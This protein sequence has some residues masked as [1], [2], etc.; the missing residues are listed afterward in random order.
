MHPRSAASRLRIVVMG[1]LIRGPIGGLAWHYLQYVMGLAALGH[2][3]LY[4]EDSDDYDSCYDPALNERTTNPTYGLAFADD[5][6]RGVGLGGCWA[7]HDSHTMRWFGPR[8]DR[9]PEF[10]RTADVCLNISG[11]NPIRPWV[12]SIPVRVLIDTDPAFTQIK[13]LTDD[14]ASQLAH[15][16]N[17]FFTFAENLPAGRSEVPDD[18]LPWQATRQ[19]VVLDA[20]PV[21]PAPKDGKYTSVLLWESYDARQYGGREYGLKAQSFGPYVM[22]PKRTGPIFELAM[23][24]PTS[25][26][27]YFQE[28]GWGVI[29]PL[30]PTRDPWSYQRYIQGSRAEF[31]VAKHAYV[32]SRSGWFSERSA[33]YLASGRPVIVQDTGFSDWLPTGHG[34][35]PFSNP[36]EVIAAI[37][38][39]EADYERHCR[40]A[41]EVA[42]SHFEAGGV[43]TKLL[44]AAWPASHRASASHRGV[45]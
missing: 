11:M 44:E 2:E 10:C 22:L 39:V 23:G 8:A 24:S 40:A 1:Y 20:W 18:G 41:R 31:G 42:Q 16:H 17:V 27:E 5:A 45:L 25:P 19:P 15:R 21:V 35:L 14:D 9:V 43:L 13:H 29:D 30:E 28:V 4:L 32:V 6:F 36:D 26:G 38:S 7:F 3:V 37:A 33:G 34:V 12:E